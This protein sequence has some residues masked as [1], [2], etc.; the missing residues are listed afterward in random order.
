MLPLPQNHIG[1]MN[2]DAGDALGNISAPTFLKP[3]E[4]LLTKGHKRQITRRKREHRRI[5]ARVDTG[6][7]IAEPPGSDWSL[8]IPDTESSFSD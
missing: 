1:S 3:T 7:A 4:I 2:G 5:Q 8:V 6:S